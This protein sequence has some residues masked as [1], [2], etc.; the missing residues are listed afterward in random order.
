MGT[1]YY[2]VKP[3]KKQLFYLGK[4]ISYLD[5]IPNRAY[6]EA[7]YCTW[8]TYTDVILDIQE[9][10]PY[11]L[12]GDLYIDQINNFCSAIFEFCDDKVCLDNDCSDTFYQYSDYEEIDVYT[13]LLTKEEQWCELINLIPREEW[14]VENHIIYEFKTIEKYLQKVKKERASYETRN[15]SNI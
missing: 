11:F 2:I 14:V 15:K 10:S 9:N 7:D 13:D 1:E 8:E 12:E 3:N 4:R 5:G 6:K